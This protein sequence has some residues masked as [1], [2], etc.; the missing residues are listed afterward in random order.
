MFA[1]SSV[2][3]WSLS[4]YPAM[5]K[6]RSHRLEL[7]T[8][9]RTS[10]HLDFLVTISVFIFYSRSCANDIPVWDTASDSSASSRRRCLIGFCSEIFTEFSAPRCTFSSACSKFRFSTIVARSR[11]VSSAFA[12]FSTTWSKR[13]LASASIQ[14]LDCSVNVPKSESVSHFRKK[15]HNIVLI[16]I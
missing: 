3:R 14:R 7:E 16:T 6:R 10:T 1:G 11:S 2:L 15:V 4:A 13:V 5:K 8:I 9:N 12:Y